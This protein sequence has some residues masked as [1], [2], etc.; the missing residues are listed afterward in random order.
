MGRDGRALHSKSLT[1]NT[2]ACFSR[3][4]HC[5]ACADGFRFVPWQRR[6]ETEQQGNVTGEP[7]MQQPVPK[8]PLLDMVTYKHYGNPEGYAQHNVFASNTA[9][10][11]LVIRMLKRLSLSEENYGFPIPTATCQ[12]WTVT[13]FCN[14]PLRVSVVCSDFFLIHERTSHPGLPAFGLV[15]SL[16]NGVP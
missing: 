1:R 2:R 15:L 16:N 5:I 14:C 10:Y 13:S 6:Q 3:A 7:T 4:V 9:E 8:N 11:L 12:S